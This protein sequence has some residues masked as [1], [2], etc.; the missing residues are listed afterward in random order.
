MTPE[1]IGR[2]V[3]EKYPQYG[4]YTDEEV[5]RKTLLKYP[6][7]GESPAQP[8][9][10]GFIGALQ[11]QL[12][13]QNKGVGTNMALGAFKGLASTADAMSQIGQKYFGGAASKIVGAVTGKPVTQTPPATLPSFV[14]EADGTAQQVGKVAEQIGEF[15]V[16]AGLTAKLSRIAEAGIKGTD[17]ATKF[18]KG[19]KA[20]A[21]VLSLASRSGLLAGEAGGVTAVQSYGKE[22]A[23]DQVRTNAIISGA[24]PIAGA[25]LGSMK[26]LVGKAGQKIQQSLIK[27]SIR[28]VKDGFKAENITKYGIGGDLEKMSQQVHNKIEELGGQLGSIISNSPVTVNINSVL[29]DVERALGTNATKNFGMNSR[30]GKA[31]DT[32]REEAKMITKDGVVSLKEAQEIKRSVGKIGAWQFGMRDPESSA[33]EKVANELYDKLKVAIEAASPEQ[34]RGINS[35]LSELI[36]IENAIIR[37]IPV[38][39]RQNALSLSDAVTAIPGLMHPGN[40]WLFALNRLSKSGTVGGALAK[41]GGEVKKDGGAIKQLIFGGQKLSPS[42]QKTAGKVTGAIE[43]VGNKGGLSIQ[44]VTRNNP[45]LQEARKYKSAEE[46]VKAKSGNQG[47]YNADYEKMIQ[48]NR[49]EAKPLTQQEWDFLDAETKGDKVKIYRLSTNGEILPGDNVSVHNVSKFINKDGS[50]NITGAKMGITQLGGR[51]DVKL[52]EQWIPKK[53]LHQ[54][55]AG[56]QVY[57]PNGT[58]SLTS[59]YHQATGGTKRGFGT[60]AGRGEGK[61]ALLKLAATSSPRL[62]GEFANALGVGAKVFNKFL[63][64]IGIRAIQAPRLPG[65]ILMDSPFGKKLDEAFK[66][67][68][69]KL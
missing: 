11:N 22:E 18:G 40:W 20:L 12:S 47:I 63:Q 62:I 55:P 8:Q 28:D 52:V 48:K 17:L 50:L 14:K 26:P 23:A 46:F 60:G 38:E 37:R 39:A 68:K 53:D 57:A 54:T 35:Q 31:I 41:M 56:T 42:E 5:G 51:K 15:F 43:S 69:N 1:E 32:L 64:T 44:D 2:R 16:P 66:T 34:I 19:G 45:L 6:Q 65:D 59:L 7:Y 27:P 13:S 30:F 49:S 10:T 36:P 67:I 21:N 61:V 9:K 33:L 25:A 4:K 24:I 29:D 58:K 3:K